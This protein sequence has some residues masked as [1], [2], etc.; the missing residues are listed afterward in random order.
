MRLLADA[1]QSYDGSA[2]PA[3]KDPA[4]NQ[5]A[6]A[7]AHLLSLLMPPREM[8]TFLRVLCKGRYVPPDVSVGREAASP[9]AVAVVR[10]W[11]ER[12]DAPRSAG[13]PSG[14]P[15]ASASGPADSAAPASAPAA[16]ATDAPA[17]ATP[18]EAK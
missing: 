8:G 15:A 18:A 13:A 11:I 4:Y 5:L 2:P 1:F 12:P 7:V 3:V 9:G 6:G 17:A 14:A 10:K 16:T